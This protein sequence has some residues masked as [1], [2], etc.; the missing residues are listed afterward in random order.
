M[1]LDVIIAWVWIL[2]GVLFSV[3]GM[4]LAHRQAGAPAIY[5]YAG[6]LMLLAVSAFKVHPALLRF[7]LPQEVQSLQDELSEAKRRFSLE[8]ERLSAARGQ[9]KT[10]ESASSAVEK[11]LAETRTSQAACVADKEKQISGGKALQARIDQDGQELETLR[12]KLP[13]LAAAEKDL[14]ESRALGS[15]CLADKENQMRGNK[16]LQ[17]RI[18]RDAQELETLRGKLS[19][20]SGE[21]KTLAGQLDSL[22]EEQHSASQA[23]ETQKALL[24]ANI[25]GLQLVEAEKSSLTEQLSNR[26]EQ[27]AAALNTV[28]E[29]KAQIANMKAPEPVAHAPK[30]EFT[31]GSAPTL[32]VQKLESRELVEGEIGDYYLIGLKDAGTGAPITFP[33][34]SFVITEKADA[35]HSAMEELREAVLKRIPE[36]WQYKIFVRGQADGGSFK[37][38]IADDAYRNLEYLPPRDASGS[39]Y[40]AQFVRKHFDGQ[41]ENEDLPNLRAAFM[42]QT[43][44][45]TIKGEAPVLLG[46][47]PQPGSN[48]ANR[49]AEIILLVKQPSE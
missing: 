12:G 44:L 43:L 49:R 46:N 26:E 32:G 35:L 6:G 8:Q 31:L 38:P 19:A 18:D 48:T 25:H 40:Q 34:A 41:Y 29:L 24:A 47:N 45:K 20:L 21:N 1:P 14:A 42:A 22:K 30:Q 5:V 13:L 2:A 23:Y 27:L 37:E 9:L 17:A 7:N 10:M 15:A 39:N 11:D 33:P 4:F 3:L 28:A 16:A 36:R